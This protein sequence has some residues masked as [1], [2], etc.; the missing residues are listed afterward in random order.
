MVLFELIGHQCS[1][2]PK[3]IRWQMKHISNRRNNDIW[4]TGRICQK[5]AACELLSGRCLSWME[6]II[7]MT[8]QGYFWTEFFCGKLKLDDSFFPPQEVRGRDEG[9]WKIWNWRKLLQWKV[10]KTKLKNFFCFGFNAWYEDN[11]GHFLAFLWVILWSADLKLIIVQF[12]FATCAN[13]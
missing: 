3:I 9:M 4:K 7:G 2:R 13:F 12:I 5:K 8:S 11:K 6:Q 10:E 1:N